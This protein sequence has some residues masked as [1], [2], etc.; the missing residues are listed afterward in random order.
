M[1]RIA[2]LL[3]AVLICFG[4]WG[5][6]ASDGSGNLPTEQEREYV[7]LVSREIRQ[8]GS[9]GFYY[10]VHTEYEYNEYGEFL[11]T[12]RYIMTEEESSFGDE[13]MVTTY[14]YAEDG[15]TRSVTM[16]LYNGSV[17]VMTYVY[18]VNGNM[19]SSSY[20]LNGEFSSETTYEYDVQGN[21][22]YNY[23]N[24]TNQQSEYVY[25]YDDNGMQTSQITTITQGNQ[26]YV[27]EM[28]YEDGLLKKTVNKSYG[29][30]TRTEFEYIDGKLSRELNYDAEGNLTSS[31]DYE[32]GER[33]LT[34]WST[35][36]TEERVM[37]EYY[38]YDEY[39]N[40]IY[41]EQYYLGEITSRYFYEYVAIPKE[42]IRK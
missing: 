35:T 42:N 10:D 12:T 34:I 38:E 1:K 41:F 21:M 18:D 27:H 20:T 37:S 3:M 29:T 24:D 39:G 40:K 33:K 13:K 25:T 36:G 11:S 32:Y 4:L 9:E 30:E 6:H 8:E 23:T 31:R 16:N 19:V 26:V 15:N 2:S 17:M 28:Y 7:Y 14:S 22:I 5:C